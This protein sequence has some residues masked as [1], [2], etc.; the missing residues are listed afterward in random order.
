MTS[1]WYMVA[2]ANMT[3]QERAEIA[4]CYEVWNSIG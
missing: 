3:I 4:E 2:F 1:L